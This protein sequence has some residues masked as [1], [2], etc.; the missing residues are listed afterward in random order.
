MNSQADIEPQV[1]RL[2]GILDCEAAYL[3]LAAERLSAV[4]RLVL[5]RDVAAL[6]EL[7]EEIRNESDER[8]RCEA[9]RRELICSLALTT[10]CDASTIT[11]SML[12]KHV[13]RDR[14]Q[15]LAE[16]KLQL[17]RLI[18]EVRKQLASTGML[19]SEMI[20][21]NRSLL[22]GLTGRTGNITYSRNGRARWAGADNILNLKY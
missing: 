16:K 3:S 9:A 22:A 15:L 2:L 19:L 7:L 1:D 18:E 8:A 20:R 12:E 17:R 11:I 6:E 13:G 21:I 5:K 10:G 14:Q 4:S